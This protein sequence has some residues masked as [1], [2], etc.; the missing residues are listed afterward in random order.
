M[1]HFD[2][3]S[4]KRVMQLAISVEAILW[5]REDAK[6]RKASQCS[7]VSQATF[8]FS[9][10]GKKQALGQRRAHYE[11][12][13]HAFCSTL[14]L[15][16]TAQQAVGI[17]WFS[18]APV[19]NFCLQWGLKNRNVFTKVLEAESPRFR[20]Q[21]TDL[22]APENSLLHLQPPSHCVLTWYLSFN[23]KKVVSKLL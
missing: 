7:G 19:T 23:K 12:K 1:K 21:H 16:A 18:R 3:S 22:M 9:T 2:L 14:V 8:I 13:W 11:G 6:K 5:G 20:C 17:Y 10:H 15:G 4:F